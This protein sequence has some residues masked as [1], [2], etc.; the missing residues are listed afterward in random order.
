MTTET[1]IVGDGP[2]AW[3][4][5]LTL[6]RQAPARVTV[7]AH[8]SPDD[9]DPFGS[10][11]TAPA[12]AR[13]HHARA[14]VSEA[15]IMA[16]AVP[17]FG[18]SLEGWSDGPAFVPSGQTGAD[19]FSVAFHQQLARLGRLDA[20][21]DH[22]L[23]AQLARERRYA[24]PSRDPASF[25]S[26]LDHG[27]SLD[28]AAYTALLRR[29][30]LK[31]GV[32]VVEGGAASVERAPSGALVA[33]ILADGAPVI[34][35]LF[36]DV[37]AEEIGNALEQAFLAQG[38]LYTDLVESGGGVGGKAD[39]IKS[40][41]NVASPLVAAKRDAGLLI[42]PLSHLYK[43]EVRQLGTSLGVPASVVGRHP[44]PGPGLAVRILGEVTQ[45]RCEL[46]RLADAIYMEE[47]RSRDLY[48]RV[49]QAFAV[50]LSVKSVGITGDSRSYG[51]VV[52][53]RAVQTADFMTAD[54]YPFDVAVLTEIGSRITNE[55]P[56]VG[57]VVYD[58]SSKPP[59]TVEW[60]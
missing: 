8:P 31:A 59:A 6:A 40:H 3:I 60:E 32:T 49:T 46:L 44:F 53:L 38:T 2:A 10:A 58:V 24:P 35:D 57:R 50:L 43:D 45:P 5:A 15:E 16:I 54:V 11:L 21:A 13:A 12:A 27:L 55:V 39:V 25:L 19:A 28:A 1:V 51:S 17:L 56:G 4:M 34:G 20:L 18:L 22:S 26:T 9:V 30:A 52:A 36:I 42:E 7:I 48:E 29:H 41:H 14:G 47:L 33:V 37:Q 23:S